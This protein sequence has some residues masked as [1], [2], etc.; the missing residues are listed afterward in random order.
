M[1][2]GTT[3]KMTSHMCSET[4]AVTHSV[5]HQLVDWPH[6]TKPNIKRGTPQ[7]YQ[8]YE[9]VISGAMAAH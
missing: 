5:G 1:H 2:E 6:G 3:I 4:L 9:A 7:Y 8:D